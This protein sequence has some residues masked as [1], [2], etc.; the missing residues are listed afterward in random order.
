[1]ESLDVVKERAKEGFVPAW[2]D[3]THADEHEDAPKWSD[4]DAR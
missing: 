3:Y 1:M 4:D 2:D